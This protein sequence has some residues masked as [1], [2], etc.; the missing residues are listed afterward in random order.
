MG[1]VGWPHRCPMR[2]PKSLGENFNSCSTQET[3]NTKKKR[4]VSKASPKSKFF[5]IGTLCGFF[6]YYYLTIDWSG[7][8]STI[9]VAVYWL[10]VPVLYDI[11]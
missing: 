6:Y 2:S 4:P 11:W 8:K 5:L 7:T 9:T 1:T 10:T 3:P